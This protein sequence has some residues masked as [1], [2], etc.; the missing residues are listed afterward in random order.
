MLFQDPIHQPFSFAPTGRALDR[1]ALMLHGF[2][3]S[4]AELR[5]LGEALR[6]DG[7]RAD[8]PTLPGFG[9]DIARLGTVGDGDWLDAARSAF[10]SIREAAASSVLI[11]FSM[12]GAVALALAAEMQPSRLILIEPFQRIPDWRARLLPFVGPLMKELKT[13]KDAHFA[14]PATRDQFELSG[15]GL[16]LDDPAVQRAIREEA[17]MPIRSLQALARIGRVGMKAAPR[18][19]CPTLIVQARP[20]SDESFGH[21]DALVATLHGPT[22]VEWVDG[23]HQLVRDNRSSWPRVRD[24]VVAF[25]SGQGVVA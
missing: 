3:G 17:T 25:A 22:R 8:A 9:S 19:T 6:S 16:D 21:P 12:G 20:Y 11:G 10:T 14:D 7:I 1:A 5:A 2:L 23:D 24:L 15:R 18:I 4:P 13:A